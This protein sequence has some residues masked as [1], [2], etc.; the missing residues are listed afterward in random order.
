MCGEMDC[1]GTV[2][3]VAEDW[4]AKTKGVSAVDAKLVGAA[5]ERI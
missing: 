2:E 4:A 5:C 1:V 3:E